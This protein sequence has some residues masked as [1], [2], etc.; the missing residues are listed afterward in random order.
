MIEELLLCFHSIITDRHSC[1]GRNLKVIRTQTE[2]MQINAPDLT[3]PLFI[4]LQS[5][6]RCYFCYSYG[7]H[8]AFTIYSRQYV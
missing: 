8:P 6:C 1:A 7:S 2:L 3:E 4:I 5:L